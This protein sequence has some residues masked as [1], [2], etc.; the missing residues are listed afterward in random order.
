MLKA[1][2]TTLFVLL[3]LSSFSFAQEKKRIEILQAVS[4]EADEHVANNA[5]RLIDS[6]LI[7]HNDILV[8]C[9]SAY[10]YTGTNRLDAFGHVHVEKGDTLHLFA[11]KVY[12]DGDKKFAQAYGDVRLLDKKTT[13]YT[14]TLDYDLEANIGYYDDHGKIVDSTNT[15]TS[16][17]GKYFV[18]SHLIYF[19]HD[20]KGFSEDYTLHSDTL[21]YNTQ[22]NRIFII[23]PTTIHDSTNTL[24]AEDG[25]YDPETGEAELKKNPVVSNE[26]KKLK[27]DYIKYN[28]E[29]GDGNAV[30]SVQ[31]TDFENSTIIEGNTADYNKSFEVATVTDSAVYMM[32]SERDTLFLHADTLRS[33]P[34]T[35][36]GENLITAFHGI[37]FFRQNVQGVCD[38]MVYFTKD[39]VVQLH[40]NPVIWSEIHQLSAD[41][42][43][44][45]QNIKAPDELRLVNNS[46]IISKQDSDRFDQIKGRNMIGYIINNKLNN[47]DVDGS[48]QTLYYA[49]EDSSII[50]LNRAES[51]KISILFKEGKIFKI[52]F[53]KA[54]QGVLKPLFE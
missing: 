24:Y 32:Y 14:D 52:A 6:V 29:N 44:M 42:I 46:F 12:Y 1:K 5:Q 9:D 21:L 10:T 34:D 36:E 50:G 25:W 28:E 18:D 8:W 23:G 26:T 7:R 43:E 15:L 17:I 51:S 54:P 35:V 19:Y 37:R 39:S 20:V 13:L 53:Q 49:R 2:L 38:S 47:I 11:N 22:N 41:V 31:I 16:I 48:G 33:V 40:Y 3:L 27:A 4:W 45:K 30:G